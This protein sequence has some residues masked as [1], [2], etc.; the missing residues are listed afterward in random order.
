MLYSVSS[1]SL[2]SIQNRNSKLPNQKYKIGSSGK[3]KHTGRLHH[4][5][6][7]PSRVLSSCAYILA[8]VRSVIM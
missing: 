7:Q 5:K 2:G 4:L 8:V 3:I 6:M 1:S